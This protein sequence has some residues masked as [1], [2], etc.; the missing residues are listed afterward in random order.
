[1]NALIDG[2][3]NFLGFNFESTVT[4]AF[5]LL[6]LL[7]LLLVFGRKFDFVLRVEG[8]GIPIALFL[9]LFALLLG[10]YGPL[11]L[12]PQSVTEI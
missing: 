6:S 11:H 1:M 2:L 5:G 7:G 8:F 3:N 10:P 4:L 9:G 12:L